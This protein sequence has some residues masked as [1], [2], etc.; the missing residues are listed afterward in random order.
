MIKSKVFNFPLIPQSNFTYVFSSF[1]VVSSMDPWRFEHCYPDE[2][3]MGEL[4]RIASKTHALTMERVTMH[5]YRC[6]LDFFLGSDM[7]V[8]E[9]RLRLSER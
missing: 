8:S 9:S 2:S 6:L 4:G 3:L 5:R 7:K 1:Y